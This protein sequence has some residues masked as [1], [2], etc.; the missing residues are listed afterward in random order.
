[1]V[2]IDVAELGEPSSVP[3]ISEEGTVSPTGVEDLGG[4]RWYDTC[5]LRNNMKLQIA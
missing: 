3:L 1:M 5:F 2:A 4:G